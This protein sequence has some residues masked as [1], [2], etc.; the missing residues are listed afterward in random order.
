MSLPNTESF[1]NCSFVLITVIVNQTSNSF[2]FWRIPSHGKNCRPEI[3]TPDIWQ[4][5]GTSQSFRLLLKSFMPSSLLSTLSSLSCA[6]W[7]AMK[8]SSRAGTLSTCLWVQCMK[9]QI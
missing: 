9:S 8:C 4:R 2:L 5:L 1:T 3:L 6:L 7:W